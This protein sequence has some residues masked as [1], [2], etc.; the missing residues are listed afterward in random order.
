MEKHLMKDFHQVG[1]LEKVFIL[2]KLKKYHKKLEWLMKLKRI[3][4]RDIK[5]DMS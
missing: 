5:L 1:S 3:T 4:R 2:I